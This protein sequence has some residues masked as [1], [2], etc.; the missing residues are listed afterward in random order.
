MLRGQRSGPITA[1][2]G[3]L[4]ALAA[5]SGAQ[6]GHLIACLMKVA[7]TPTSL[8]PDHDMLQELYRAGGAPSAT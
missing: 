4:L 2:Q 7:G 3:E 6:L 5:E 8:H 1:A